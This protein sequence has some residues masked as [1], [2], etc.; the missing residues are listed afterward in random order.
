MPPDTAEV[1]GRKLDMLHR[2]LT[3]MEYYAALD[4][5]VQRQEHYAI[6]RLLQLLCESAADIGLQL[7]RRDG[8]RLASAYREVFIALRD[9]HGLDAGLADQLVDA[10]A[11]RNVLTH[12]Y[13][14]IDL[15][16]VIGAVPD[17][18]EVYSAFASWAGERVR[19][20]P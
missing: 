14:T 4:V 19:S 15:D 3:D 7:L 6:E 10:C 12:L 1:I 13:D 16:R 5:S 20:S 17:A 8:D 18:L 9:R 2:F 11:M